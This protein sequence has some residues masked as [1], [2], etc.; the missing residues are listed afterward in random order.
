MRFGHNTLVLVINFI[1]SMRVPCHV[2]VQ[3]FE[4]IDTFRVTMIVHVK[5][6]LSSYNLLTN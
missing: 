3:L 4:A 6:L 1:N 2:I 5:D